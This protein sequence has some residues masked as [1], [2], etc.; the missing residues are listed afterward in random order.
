[1]LA[2]QGYDSIPREIPDPKAKK[3]ICFFSCTIYKFCI[4]KVSWLVVI[5][6][7]P[8]I[9][10]LIG[11]KMKMVYG[12]RQ[13]FLIQHIRDHGNARWCHILSITLFFALLRNLFSFNV[14]TSV[15]YLYLI[16]N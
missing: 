4:E 16:E 10:L 9:S 5:L 8:L 6:F 7:D 14:L 1:M 11:M 2:I 15:T 13:R 3:V 12:S